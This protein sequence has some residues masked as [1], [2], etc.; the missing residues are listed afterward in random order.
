MLTV[1]LFQCALYNTKYGHH[2]VA[3]L[4]VNLLLPFQLLLQYLKLSC[5]KQ[6][7]L[8]WL[9]VYDSEHIVMTTVTLTTVSI[10]VPVV[11][12]GTGTVKLKASSIPI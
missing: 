7:S 12:E 1:S 11:I 3:T 8:L 5:L 10:C 6:C 9:L 2:T 4:P